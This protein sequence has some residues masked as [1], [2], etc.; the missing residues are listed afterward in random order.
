M[1]Y[2]IGRNKDRLSLSQ[3]ARDVG[4]PRTTVVRLLET[5]HAVGAVKTASRKNEYQ[6]G[7]K[8]VALL[9][10]TS[11]T[12]QILAIAQ[13]SL[14]RLAVETGETVYLCLPDG[15]RVLFASQ[16]DSRYKIRMDD[17]TG[18]RTPMHPTAAG[19]LFLAHRSPEAQMTYM[20]RELERYTELTL[21][22][23]EAF[24]DQFTQILDSGISWTRDEF[25]IGYIGVAAPI[26]NEAGDVV[27]AAALSAPKFRIEDADHEERVGLLV[28]DTAQQITK[29]VRNSSR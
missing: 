19:K 5:L 27:G 26:F 17:S 29:R 1:L 22:S 10:G 24:H 3:L 28:R 12:E 20:G 18:W 6:L 4:L 7:D 15:E 8:L 2:T 23:L 21:T 16:I 9:T 25:E 13:P 11:W 14:Q